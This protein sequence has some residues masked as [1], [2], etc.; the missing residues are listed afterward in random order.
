[1]H[2]SS[3]KRGS[4][5]IYHGR[6]I[7]LY[8]HIL[9]RVVIS[10]LTV[11]AIANI[12]PGV[13]VDNIYWALL[14]AVVLGLLNV[15]VKPVLVLLTLPITVVTLGGFLLVL[16]ALLFWFAGYVLPGFHVDGFLAAFVGAL[17]L[18]VVS[19]LVNHL[20]LPKKIA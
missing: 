13:L 5:S 18:S 11:M 17:F 3:A 6:D 15:L 9:T 20:L 19:Y 14:V 10:A 7:L 16:N 2:N 12:V 1:M 4:I 8:M